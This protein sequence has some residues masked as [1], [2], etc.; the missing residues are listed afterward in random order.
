ME[1]NAL[2]DHQIVPRPRMT[3]TDRNIKA[4]EALTLLPDTFEG[5]EASRNIVDL[6]DNLRQTPLDRIEQIFTSV[7]LIFEIFKIHLDI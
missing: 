2:E 7:R 4:L 3:N 1:T 6:L 5:T